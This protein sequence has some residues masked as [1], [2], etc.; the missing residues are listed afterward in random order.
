M[1]NT[2]PILKL[3]KT[4][5]WLVPAL[6]VVMACFPLFMHLD[7][8]P[9]RI[10]DESRQAWNAFE[11]W[12]NGNYLVTYFQGAPDMWSTK[13][14][15]LIWCQALLFGL[16]GPGELALRLPSAVAALLTGW[17]LLRTVARNLGASWM[18][19][20]ACAVLYTNQGYIN[21]HV[22]RS[23]DYDAMLVLFMSLSAWA[24]YRWTVDGRPR[25]V[26][27]FFILLTLGVLTKSVQALLFLPGL[28]LFLLFEKKV[29]TL[30]RLRQTYFGLLLF[31][32]VVG[33]FYALRESANPGYLEAVW[34]NELGGRYGDALEG[35]HG[36]WNYYVSMLIEHHF[37]PWWWLV[38]CG[39]VLGFAHRNPEMRRWTLLL[40]C[41]GS[42]YLFI[43]SSAGTKLEW[44]EAPLF[45]ILS[46]LAAIAIYVPFVWLQSENLFTPQLRG[47]VL[48]YLLLFL[49][50][51]GPYSSTVG[52]MYFPK[53][54]AWDEERYAGTKFLQSMVRGTEHTQVDA[55]CYDDYNA[56]NAF[57][58][59]LLQDRGERI[60]CIAKPDLTT[61]Q[62]AMAWEPFVKG[63]IE[64]HY[65]VDLVKEDGPVRIYLII[66]EHNG[67]P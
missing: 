4:N 27:F 47:R 45:P 34:M 29:I 61:G 62:R 65:T 20:I 22:A 28:F 21:M 2:D 12:Q 36:P 18:G 32:L 39:I 35:H 7:V 16:I 48:P 49:G 25:Q 67:A 59:K 26:L 5:A 53:E 46:A 41:V 55:V 11:M 13:P 51:V 15:L 9:I 40:V 8:L 50:F 42:A 43:M 19:L 17:F 54:W 57:Y 63:Y 3:F 10:W 64:S 56:Q 30:F 31:V 23:G 58:V 37:V 52:R 66:G 33:G 24:L 44:Y 60:D 38:P 1:S 6:F 14:P